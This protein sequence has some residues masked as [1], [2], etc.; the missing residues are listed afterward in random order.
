MLLFAQDDL[1]VKGIDFIVS[2]DGDIVK[3][4]HRPKI[5]AF[6]PG[7]GKK[8]ISVSYHPGNLSLDKSDMDYLWSADDSVKLFLTF[9]YYHY[10]PK[11]NQHVSNY[12]I[13]MAKS[14]LEQKYLVLYILNTRKKPNKGI[15]PLPGK[16]YTFE[17][18]YPGGQMIKLRKK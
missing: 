16:D 4:I 18:D 2:I 3:S 12:E 13:A 9:E 5:V 14:W 7:L 17:L 11:G 15:V 10:T 1:T 6:D 8:S